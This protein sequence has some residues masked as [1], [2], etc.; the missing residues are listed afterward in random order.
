MAILVRNLLASKFAKPAIFALAIALF[1]GVAI[2]PTFFYMAD[3]EREIEQVKIELERQQKLFPIF[4]RLLKA[5]REKSPE[6]LPLP[7]TTKLSR[8]NTGQATGMLRELAADSN[9]EVETISPDMQT[10]LK[11]S[12][13]LKVKAVFQGGIWE[14]RDL[15]VKLGGV[16]YLQHVDDIKL[17]TMEASHQL[18]FSLTLWLNQE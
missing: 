5:S 17:Q 2:V 13:F 6:L 8:G 11:G 9:L 15:L 10:I 3:T 7:A 14:F 16:P 12:Q 1:V 4:V 18:R